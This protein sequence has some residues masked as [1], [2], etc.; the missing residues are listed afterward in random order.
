MVGLTYAG[1]HFLHVTGWRFSI[2]LD[3]SDVWPLFMSLLIVVPVVMG[4]SILL[5]KKQEG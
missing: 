2:G 3:L 1:S 4:M 5:L